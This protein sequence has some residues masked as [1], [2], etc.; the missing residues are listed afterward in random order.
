MSISGIISENITFL[1][2]TFPVPPSKRAI[3]KVN[4]F[5]PI[6]SIGNPFIGTQ[7]H[8]PVL[9]IYTTERNVNVK[10]QCTSIKYGQ[11]GNGNL[12]IRLR[13]RTEPLNC[14]KGQQG[15]VYCTGSIT[16]Q[17][18]KP[19][20]FSF[21]LGF[22]C[23]DIDAMSSLKGLSYNISIHEQINE[24]NCIQLPYNKMKLCQQYYQYTTLPNLMGTQDLAAQKNWETLKMY[25]TIVDGL[26]YQHLVEF[27]CHAGLPECDSESRLVIHPCREMCHDWRKACSNVTLPWSIVSKRVPHT[28]VTWDVTSTNVD[29]DYLPSFNGDIPCFYKPVYCKHPPVVT[30]GTLVSTKSQQKD[31]YSVFDTLVYSCD[32]GFSLKGNKTVTCTYKGQ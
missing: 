7:D 12:K 28:S 20:K 24:T 19:R 26:C 16:V 4:A 30:N 14:L 21:S 6:S 3:I 22:R 17:D 32:E 18:F 29:C 10:S 13:P 8:L 5:Y 25:L 2:K 27:G 31:N 9:E 1:H 11:L 23:K 15:F